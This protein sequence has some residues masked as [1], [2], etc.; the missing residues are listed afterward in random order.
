MDR[1][2]LQSVSQTNRPR[3]RLNANGFTLLELIIAVTILASF[4]LPMLLILSKSKV[5]TIKMTQE[6]QLRDLAQR[7]LFDRIHYYIEENEGVFDERPEWTWEIP[8]PEVVNQGN[9][10]QQ[11]LLEYRILVYTPQQIGQ[12]GATAIADE[13]AEE[14]VYEMSV[15]TFPDEEWYAEQDEL[16]ARGQ[17][18]ILHGNPNYQQP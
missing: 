8:L 11:I 4:V 7:T 15:W 5:R 13:E 18:S 10:G 3:R 6:R 1:W 17:Y 12:A 14:S 9:Q 16:Y 2:N